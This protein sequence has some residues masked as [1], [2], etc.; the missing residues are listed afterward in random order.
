M[1]EWSCRA[2]RFTVIEGQAQKESVM[3]GIIIFLTP[4]SVIYSF[5]GEKPDF[6]PQRHSE[7]QEMPLIGGFECLGL[8][9]FMV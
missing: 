9:F 4:R 7:W 1:A 6:R 5:R 8:F 3:G 2:Q